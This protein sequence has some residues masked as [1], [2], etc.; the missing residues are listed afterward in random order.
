MG[1]WNLS[2]W[3]NY[4]VCFGAGVVFVLLVSFFRKP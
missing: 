1:H 2:E 4:A 3:G